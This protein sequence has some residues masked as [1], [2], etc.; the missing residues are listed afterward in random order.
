VP[1][2]RSNMSKTIKDG[3]TC[4]LE[5]SLTNDPH[6]SC[7]P[8]QNIEHHHF[9]FFQVTVTRSPSTGENCV[10]T[11]VFKLQRQPGSRIAQV[12]ARVLKK[13]ISKAILHWVFFLYLGTRALV[14]RGSPD[15][16]KSKQNKPVPLYSYRV[17]VKTMC[18]SES[19]WSLYSSVGPS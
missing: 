19:Q 16:T 6:W 13:W 8:Y 15:V 11:K 4:C 14:Q 5:A 9:V 7:A 10:P 3:Q 1:S 12:A 18:L 17:D 2:S